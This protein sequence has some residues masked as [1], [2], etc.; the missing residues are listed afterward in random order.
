MREVFT[1]LISGASLYIPPLN[2][3]IETGK[4]L[5]WLEDDQITIQHIVPTLADFL[6]QSSSSHVTLK[7]LRWLFFAW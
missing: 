1:P 7:N 3:R 4:Y 6:M 2:N 5:D